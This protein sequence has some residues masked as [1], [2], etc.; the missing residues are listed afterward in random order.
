MHMDADGW[1][2]LLRYSPALL[3]ETGPLTE[4]GL[5]WLVTEA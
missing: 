2:S 4:L 3:L 5:E 1:V